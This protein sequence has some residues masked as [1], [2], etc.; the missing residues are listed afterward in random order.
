MMLWPPLVLPGVS[1][2]RPAAADEAEPRA[3]QQP[4]A[5]LRRRPQRSQRT[6][7][8]AELEEQQRNPGAT[9][10]YVDDLSAAIATSPTFRYPLG[11]WRASKESC[12]SCIAQAPGPDSGK[13]DPRE[14]QKKPDAMDP[15]EL[16]LS[17]NTR[18]CGFSWSDAAAKCGPACPM[19]L[20]S[21]CSA[22]APHVGVNST[23]P[24]AAH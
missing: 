17:S 21:E 24:A 5:V 4:L 8:V 9:V 6:F 2:M 16:Q 13:I 14:L 3:L 22:N 1:A 7:S 23:C 20:Q 15:R 10:E 11:R 12:P 18:R 19:G